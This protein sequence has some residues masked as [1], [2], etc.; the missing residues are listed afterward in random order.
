MD[1]LENINDLE[2]F[3][4]FEYV[5]GEFVESAMDTKKNVII[6][7]LFTSLVHE[8][9]ISKRELITLLSKYNSIYVINKKTL[10]SF[11]AVIQGDLLTHRQFDYIKNK[12][13]KKLKKNKQLSECWIKDYDYHFYNN[14]NII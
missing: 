7:E 11:F 5:I 4:I 8:F 13:L 1:N 12:S 14:K 2:L 9:E 10:D 3:E 6:G